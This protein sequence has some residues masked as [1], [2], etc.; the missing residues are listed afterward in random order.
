VLTLIGGGAFGNSPRLIW[1]AILW[2]LAETESVVSRDLDVIVNGRNI[3]E[4]IDRQTIVAAVR[5][6][7][8]V[9]LSCPRGGPASIHR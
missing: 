6:R 4:Q 8:G 7:G 3:A 9:L 1:E 5:G 2:A